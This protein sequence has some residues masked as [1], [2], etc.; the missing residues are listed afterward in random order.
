MS[1]SSNDRAHQVEFGKL[2]GMLMRRTCTRRYGRT[3]QK[4]Q[5]SSLITHLMSTFPGHCLR[6]YHVRSFWTT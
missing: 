2:I 1:P 3:V 4:R 5:S 6:S